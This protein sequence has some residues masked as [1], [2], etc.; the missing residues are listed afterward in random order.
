MVYVSGFSMTRRGSL[1]VGVVIQVVEGPKVG[2]V[3]AK[4]KIFFV[5]MCVMLLVFVPLT[6]F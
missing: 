2:M 4:R 3:F 6:S 1:A 5:V